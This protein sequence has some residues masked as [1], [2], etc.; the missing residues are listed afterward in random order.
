MDYIMFCVIPEFTIGGP[1][2]YGLRF[3][4]RRFNTYLYLIL[5]YNIICIY[6]VICRQFYYPFDVHNEVGAAATAATVVKGV[7]QLKLL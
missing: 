7:S 5:V 3:I 2:P 4:G 6:Y 1:A